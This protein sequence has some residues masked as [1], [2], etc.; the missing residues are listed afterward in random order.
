[1]ATNM[2][3]ALFLPKRLDVTSRKWAWYV[4]SVAA[5]PL[6]R[7]GDRT[8]IY[9]RLG[10]RLRSDR[11][12]PGCF[13]QS[14]RIDLGAG[15]SINYGCF[16]ENCAPV[17][18]GQNTHVGFYVRI[19]TSSHESGGADQRAGAWHPQPVRIG[20]GC[21]IG[22][23]VTILPGVYVGDGCVIA[24]GAVVADDCEPDGLYAGIPARR[25]RDLASSTDLTPQ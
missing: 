6:L 25:V 13:F 12:K 22:V 8:M 4:N 14:A 10:M 16:I 23:G 11:L 21:W 18:I 20:N 3:R 5:S 15:S 7:D 2:I 24:A 9:R 17:E 1:M 19:I